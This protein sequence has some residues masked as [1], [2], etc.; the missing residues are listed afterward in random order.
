MDVYVGVMIKGWGSEMDETGKVREVNVFM[1]GA[2]QEE[3]ACSR[4]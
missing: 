4:R 3:G 1:L 2:F